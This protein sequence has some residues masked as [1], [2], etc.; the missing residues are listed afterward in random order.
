MVGIGHNLGPTM[1]RG[2]SWRRYAWRRARSELLPKLP[3]EVA[4]R[5]VRRARELGIDY[6]AYAGIR[7]ATGRDIIA[8]LFSS[9]ALR[10]LAEEQLAKDREGKLAEVRQADLLALIHR[11][12]DPDR[13]LQANPVLANAAQAPRA[14]AAWS[15]TRRTI[16]TLT[17]KLPPDSVVV[18]GDTHDERLWPD[19]ARLAGYLPA[20]A[21]FAPQ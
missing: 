11:P 13:V 17:G 4:R 3:L 6:K 14:F 7:A 21:Y 1:E 18:V 19:C 10:L 15:E 9:N 20:D 2:A 8:L 16:L 12:L 5:R